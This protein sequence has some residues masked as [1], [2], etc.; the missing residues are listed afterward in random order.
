MNAQM[1]DNLFVE[2]YMMMNFEITFS[3]V[4]A[5]FEMSNAQMD[6]VTLYRNLLFPE[7]ISHE[8]QAEMTRMVIYRCEDVFFQ[9][10]RVDE[11]SEEPVHP[12]RDV[13]EP[14]HQLLLRLMHVRS[15]AA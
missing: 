1:M 10:N 6:D 11:P 12:L 3:G 2:S 9:V 5:W 15:F 14:M 7:Q 8:K 13:N 4:R